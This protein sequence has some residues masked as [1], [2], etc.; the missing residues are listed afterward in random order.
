MDAAIRNRN[1]DVETA[2]SLVCVFVYGE[3]KSDPPI[4]AHIPFLLLISM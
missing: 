3:G 2:L 1:A 4:T